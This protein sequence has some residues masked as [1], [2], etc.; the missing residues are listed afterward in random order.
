M[1]T[2]IHILY[3]GSYS[4]NDCYNGDVDNEQDDYEMKKIIMTE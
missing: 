1:V 3:L 4:N 2:V